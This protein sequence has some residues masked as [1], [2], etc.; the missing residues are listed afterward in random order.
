MTTINSG[1]TPFYVWVNQIDNGDIVNGGGKE[2]VSS[3]GEADATTVSSGGDFVVE[4]GG[5][6]NGAI[7]SSGG[8]MLVDGTASGTQVDAGGTEWVSAGGLDNG[9]T[10]NG[11]TEI[12]TAGGTI[13]GTVMFL[14][15]GTLVVQQSTSFTSGARL[16]DFNSPSDVL[17]LADISY[18]NLKS[19][20]WTQTTSTGGTLMLTDGTHTANIALLGQYTEANF[21]FTAD[22]NGGTDIIDPPAASPKST[23]PQ[24]F[25]FTDSFTSGGP[26]IH[27]VLDIQP[28]DTSLGVLISTEV[29]V[30]ATSQF[31]GLLYGGGGSLGPDVSLVL[32]NNTYINGSNSAQVY[33]DFASF[34]ST[35]N[36]LVPPG[37]TT[38]ASFV[39][40]TGGG[41]FGNPTNTAFASDLSGNPA[42]DPQITLADG[43]VQGPY[44]N[45]EETNNVQV[46]VQYLYLRGLFTTGD[47]DVNFGSLT[48]D[49]VAVINAAPT[50]L[51]NAL[52]GNDTIVLPSE[53]GS[54]NYVLSPAVTASWDPTQTF[55][56][57]ATT[58]TSSNT[59]SVTA[60]NGNYKIATVGPAAVNVNVGTGTVEITSAV[61]KTT[62]IN[63]TGSIGTLKIDDPST[64]QGIIEGFVPGDKIDL[65]NVPYDQRGE[66]TFFETQKQINSNGQSYYVLQVVGGGQRLPIGFRCIHGLERR[67]LAQFR[68][69]QGHRHHAGSYPQLCYS[70]H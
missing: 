1:N 48:P 60:G 33:F 59:D 39:E 37:A 30:Q 62:T 54:G 17:D 38:T 64:F 11:G 43:I 5:T 32:G 12:V 29:T 56:V 70:C 18:A 31:S 21:A 49:Q 68:W 13:S 58:D 27:H 22:P 44:T 51:Y 4:A 53:D 2:I 20:H 63:F 16:A 50:Q 10:L 57:G 46:S 55:T 15:S 23:T 25:S 7:V 35:G 34:S 19:V 45:V 65:A 61:D 40:A 36:A 3:G 8:N 26:T 52:G 42:A 41:D 69:Q 66:A 6:A 28:F 47:D 9:T 14:G 24:T 67:F